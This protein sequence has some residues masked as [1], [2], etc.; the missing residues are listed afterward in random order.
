[1]NTANLYPIIITPFSSIN[2]CKVI[3]KVK[4]YWNMLLKVTRTPKSSE[5]QTK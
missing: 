4:Q 5:L 1:M 2:G 3:E